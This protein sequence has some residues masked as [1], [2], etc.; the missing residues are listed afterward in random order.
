[1]KLNLRRANAS[2]RFRPLLAFAVLA[3][4][5][6]LPGSADATGAKPV[7]ACSSLSKSTVQDYT[8]LSAA[9]FEATG[10]VPEH[11]RLL[12][13]LPPAIVFEVVLAAEWNGGIVM[14]ENGGYAGNSPDNP[15][16]IRAAERTVADE[17]VSVYTN[18]GHDWA[19]E[20]LGT[21]AFNSR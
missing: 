9:D 15:G 21:F 11:C 5:A 3:S 10:D 16:R 1:M 12:G 4:V 2:S 6:S 8:I 19:A 17:F 13:V 20:Q 7:T 14:R 18:T